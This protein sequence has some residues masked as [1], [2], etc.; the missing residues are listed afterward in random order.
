MGV[1]ATAILK[2]KLLFLCCRA[3]I[4]LPYAGHKERVGIMK[5]VDY[6]KI[7]EKI[8]LFRSQ[9][10]LSQE[11]LGQLVLADF[12]H[13][14]RVETGKRRPSLELIIQLANALSVSA[15]DILVDSLEHPS[16]SDEF[17]SFLLNCTEKEKEIVSRTLKFVEELFSEF[18][19]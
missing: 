15:D 16:S 13:I 4:R 7:G 12:N 11:Q 9:K 6:A 5:S 14:S 1:T 3:N 17:H 19:L 10:G 2:H 8:S 18:Q